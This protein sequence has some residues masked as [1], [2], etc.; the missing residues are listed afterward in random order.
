[1]LAGIPEMLVVPLKKCGTHSWSYVK[2]V[3]RFRN[4]C[5]SGGVFRGTVCEVALTCVI[6]T[7]VFT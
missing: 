3:T 2:T 1:V 4:Y 5:V 7:Y 6:K